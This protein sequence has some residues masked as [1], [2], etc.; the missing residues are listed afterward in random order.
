MFFPL[1]Y[2]NNPL[3]KAHFFFTFIFTPIQFHPK[4]KNQLF[5]TTSSGYIIDLTITE[6]RVLSPTEI[7]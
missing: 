5:D 4:E 3:T 7:S 6:W 1:S 2:K